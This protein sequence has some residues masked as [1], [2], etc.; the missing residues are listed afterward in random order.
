M[1]DIYSW[2]NKNCM[3][4]LLLILFLWVGV[5]QNYNAQSKVLLIGNSLTYYNSMPNILQELLNESDTNYFVN[6]RSFGGASLRNHLDRYH[7]GKNKSID[8][9]KIKRYLELGM[10][11]SKLQKTFKYKLNID[12]ITKSS[13]HI[14]LEKDRYDYVIIQE[15]GS[16]IEVDTLLKYIAS[17]SLKRFVKILNSKQEPLPKLIYFSEYPTKRSFKKERLPKIVSKPYDT[18]TCEIVDD[19]SVLRL[20]SAMIQGSTKLTHTPQEEADIII[21]NLISLKKIHPFSI[22]PIA[23]IFVELKVKQP[24]WK[25]Y[26]IAGHPSRKASFMFAC[27]Y[28]EMITK[29]DVTKTKFTGKISNKKAR[30]IKEMVHSYLLNNP[31]E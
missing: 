21:N 30:I 23:S 13:L 29:K 27:V 28:Y 5:S 3:V 6:H 8:F 16:L 12:T 1:C 2:A 25:M 24:H 4:K 18:N 19:T 11:S 31:V 20:N 14:L 17:K 9:V 10:N 26:R 22:S 7:Y 15:H